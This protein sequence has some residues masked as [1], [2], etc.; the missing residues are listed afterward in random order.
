LRQPVT[1]ISNAPPPTFPVSN[2]DLES[3]LEDDDETPYHPS[4]IAHAYNDH[5]YAEDLENHS[6]NDPASDP[7]NSKSSLSTTSL[8]VPTSS[9]SQVTKNHPTPSPTTSYTPYNCRSTETGTS[10]DQRERKRL[11]AY[12]CRLKTRAAAKRLEREEQAA[13]EH[14]SQLEAYVAQLREEVYD[15]RSTLLLHADCDCA[16]IRQYLGN[17]ARLAVL[18][19][20]SSDVIGDVV[21]EGGAGAQV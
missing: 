3:D 6:D 16:L 2:A 18:H 1:P 21:G 13:A 11:A 12:R 10:A 19:T 20:G 4:P 17:A 14:R 9:P 8:G 7:L 15:L 5:I